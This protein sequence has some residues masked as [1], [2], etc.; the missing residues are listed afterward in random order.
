MHTFTVLPHSAMSISLILPLLLLHTLI[1]IHT[2]TFT[3]YRQYLDRVVE[4]GGGGGYV[5]PALSTPLQH[6]QEPIS[7]AAVAMSALE[8]EQQGEGNSSSS[9]QQ[10]V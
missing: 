9:A 1:C 8:A 2:H 10:Q 7:Y 4:Q 3:H 6:P 5:S